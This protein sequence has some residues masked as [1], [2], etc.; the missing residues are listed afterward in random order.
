L[1]INN[2][3]RGGNSAGTSPSIDRVTANAGV[4]H[5]PSETA[6]AQAQPQTDDDQ[7]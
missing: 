5:E 4:V 1:R 7:P 2:E 3:S 6:I